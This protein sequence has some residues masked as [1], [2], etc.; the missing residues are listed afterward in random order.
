MPARTSVR[1]SHVGPSE[2]RKGPQVPWYLR[3]QQPPLSWLFTQQLV[4]F[5]FKF[6][7]SS[8]QLKYHKWCYRFWKN[9]FFKVCLNNE[10]HCPSHQKKKKKE[11]K[12]QKQ[13][14]QLLGGNW[15]DLAEEISVNPHSTDKRRK[16][17]TSGNVLK[18]RQKCSLSSLSP[19]IPFYDGIW[20][21]FIFSPWLITWASSKPTMTSLE[22]HSGQDQQLVSQTLHS[23][24]YR[25]PKNL[26]SYSFFFFSIK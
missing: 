15:P 26:I 21:W 12:I 22:K 16:W 7:L 3:S 23:F 25:V 13:L 9:C 8:S 11:R 10:E 6:S 17:V 2:V 1:L 4:C 5:A 14:V 24:L 20:S 18:T 19:T